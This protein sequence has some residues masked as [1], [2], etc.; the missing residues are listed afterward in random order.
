MIFLFKLY[1]IFLKKYT[2]FKLTE[3]KQLLHTCGSKFS[4]HEPYYVSGSEFISIG[5]N[6][7]LGAFIQ[8]WGQGGLTIE[9]DCL[10]A[11]H[12]TITTLTHD[13]NT[14]KFNE[15]TLSMPIHIGKNVWI[16]THAIILPGVSIGDNSIIGAG[17]IVN[18]NIA[19]NSVVV[20]APARLI[21]TLR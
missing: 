11:S 19:A 20:G 1:R 18:K 5:N 2:E 15:K 12:V 8:I 3:L 17:T 6:V 10:I 4:I 16:G 7:R 13:Q 9:D 21:K 14:K